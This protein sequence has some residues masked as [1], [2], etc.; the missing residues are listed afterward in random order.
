MMLVFLVL[1]LIFL[2]STLVLA[3][4]AGVASVAT[5]AASAAPDLADADSTLLVPE[6][7]THENEASFNPLG[8]NPAANNTGDT[9]ARLVL[10]MF[11]EGA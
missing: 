6:P 9:P 10:T 7:Q 11:G 8:G 5:K 3:L 4:I 2:V 1:A